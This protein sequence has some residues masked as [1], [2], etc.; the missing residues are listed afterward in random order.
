MSIGV[1]LLFLFA[2]RS[3]STPVSVSLLANLMFCLVCGLY[4][5][6]WYLAHA[7]RKIACAR[8]EGLEGEYLL[9]ELANRGGTSW[10]AVLVLMFGPLVALV[11][12]GLA[13]GLLI[14]LLG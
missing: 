6:A 4:G 9:R 14:A 10:L 1:Q 8:A 5:N 11:G 13:L 3:D 2:F 7:R 12:L